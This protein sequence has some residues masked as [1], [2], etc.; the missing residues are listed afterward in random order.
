VCDRVWDDGGLFAGVAVDLTNPNDRG[1]AKGLL[2]ALAG[3]VV[4]ASAA[5]SE[6]L[7]DHDADSLHRFAWLLVR[8]LDPAGTTRLGFPRATAL[9]HP[10]SDTR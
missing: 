1:L 10:P 9:P 3:S 6:A 5:G 8:L 2:F 7:P 4:P